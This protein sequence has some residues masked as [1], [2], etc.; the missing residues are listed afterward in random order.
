MFPAPGTVRT[1]GITTSLASMV[2]AMPAS[3]LAGHLLLAVVEARNPGTWTTIPAGWTQ[4]IAPTSAASVGNFTVFTKT[5]S[6]NEGGT[7][8]TW[9]LSLTSTASWQVVAISGWDGTTPPAY[10]TANSGGVVSS[11]NPP[12]LTSPW[13]TA[14]T[15]WLALMGSSANNTT[16]SAAPAGYSGLVSNP[17]SSGGSQCNTGFA[18]RQHSAAAEDPGSFTTTADRWWVAATVA[19]PGVARGGGATHATDFFRFM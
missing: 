15:L 18:Y 17:V 19:I 7:T 14:D 6:G 1:T 12:S 2:V 16:V 10:A 3:T 9:V 11:N 8:A 5:A 4:L 13:G